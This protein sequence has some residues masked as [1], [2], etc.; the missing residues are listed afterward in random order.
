MILQTKIG[1]TAGAAKYPMLKSV[2]SA[3]MSQTSDRHN[4]E[5][6]L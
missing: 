4:F 6:L 1:R 5:P 2:V 3:E